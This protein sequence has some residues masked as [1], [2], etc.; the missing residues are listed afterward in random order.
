MRRSLK[1]RGREPDQ[2]QDPCSEES[3]WTKHLGGR[4]C[5]K[6]E[7]GAE[8]G[9]HEG[10]DYETGAGLVSGLVVR[11][12]LFPHSC[13]EGIVDDL[14]KENEPGHGQ[15]SHQVNDRYGLHQ[16]QLHLGLGFDRLM[17]LP[18]PGRVHGKD[19]VDP[20]PDWEALE[21]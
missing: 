2:E 13:H 10:E 16:I 15:G 20:S 18:H 11:K 3:P 8:L 6:P 9:E 5:R 14:D 17:D 19:V 4:V 1:Q 21:P 7:G 12:A